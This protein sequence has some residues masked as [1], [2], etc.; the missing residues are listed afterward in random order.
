M[1]SVFSAIG[2]LLNAV[3]TAIAKILTTLVTA[4]VAVCGKA[5]I[6]T[7]SFLTPLLMSRSSPQSSASSSSLCVAAALVPGRRTVSEIADDRET[8]NWP[9][10]ALPPL[11]T[12]LSSRLQ[13]SHVYLRLSRM[14]RPPSA[15]CSTI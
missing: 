10:Q 13:A 15:H 11:D 7:V 4:A 8:R 14:L 2:S 9:L 1:G 3:I 6:S 5:K 12:H